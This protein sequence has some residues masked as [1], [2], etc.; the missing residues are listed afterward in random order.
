MNTKAE[1]VWIKQKEAYIVPIGDI[2]LGDN[3]FTD[4]SERK[5]KGYI[6][7]VRKRQNARIILMGD[8][9]NVSTRIS[10]TTPFQKMSLK[11]EMDY[12]I[13]LFRPVR[14]K[15]IG[16]IDGNHEYRATDF[17]DY[18]PLIPFC[19]YLGVR[20][21]Q[22]SA[23]FRIGVG[24]DNKGRAGKPELR[25]N[26]NYLIYAHHTTGGGSTVGGRINRV[27]KLRQ[28]LVNA[29][30]YLGAHNHALISAPVEGFICDV[31]SGNISR[32]RQYIIDCGSY[33][34]W[35]ES[36]AEMRMY[37]PQKLGSPRIRLDG[38]KKDV[39]V[40]L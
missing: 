6:E 36:Y 2:H 33:L 27:D 15:I 21:F 1:F 25:P 8:I 18:S 29:D 35:N 12:A 23:V 19:H 37:P 30:I 34:D 40:S 11:D 20:Y 7:W 31:R 38:R 16:A 5:L 17:M 24:V 26:V 28:I 13:E 3:A 4:E 9:F 39:H 10:K 22:Y 32:I 14:K